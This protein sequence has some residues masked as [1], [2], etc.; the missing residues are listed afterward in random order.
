MKINK[1]IVP[2]LSLVLI[3][4]CGVPRDP[5]PAGSPGSSTG[6]PDRPDRTAEGRDR[7]AGN[8]SSPG[9]PGLCPRARGPALGLPA[10]H[11]SPGHRRIRQQHPDP[12]SKHGIVKKI[13]VREGE[14]VT[15]GQLLAELDGAI[16]ESSMDELEN[17]LRWS[18]PF[19]KDR[20]VFGKR[21]SAA[22]SNT[23]RPKT[24]RRTWK[25]DWTPCR[26]STNSPRSLPDQRDR[27]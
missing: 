12:G 22:R 4:A 21:T 10:L 8:N 20:T 14:N 18:R 2:V 9:S 26:N 17:S 6:S 5:K 27:G 1:I 3:S 7:A 23:C 13:H 15:Q 16:L 19:T 24:T 25:K 11:P